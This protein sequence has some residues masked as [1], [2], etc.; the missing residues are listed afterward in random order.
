MNALLLALTMTMA[1]TEGTLGGPG[2]L[3]ADLPVRTLRATLKPAPFPLQMSLF[4]GEVPRQD[5]IVDRSEPESFRSLCV[6]FELPPCV[7][8]LYVKQ[9]APSVEAA[10]GSMLKD[11]P[12]R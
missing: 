12:Q 1:N 3:A 4:G 2:T 7:E 9:I 11:W 6:A 10:G 8:L 5:P